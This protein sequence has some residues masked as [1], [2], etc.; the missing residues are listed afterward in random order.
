MPRRIYYERKEIYDRLKSEEDGIF[1]TYKDILLLAACVARKEGYGKGSKTKK[2]EGEIP[3]TVLEGNSMNIAIV[4]AI[5]LSDTQNLNILLTTEDSFDKKITILEEYANKGIQ[6]L[7]IKVLDPPGD[8][9]DN[10]VNYISQQLEEKEEEGILE[11][12]DREF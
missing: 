2:R 12:I 1:S 11:S 6:I 5:A 4:N 9:L 8:P 10:L 3:W 7:K